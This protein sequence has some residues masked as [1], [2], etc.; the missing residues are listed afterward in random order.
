MTAITLG[1]CDVT[2]FAN[3]TR[4]RTFCNSENCSVISESKFVHRALSGR[5]QLQIKLT[6]ESL[7]PVGIIYMWLAATGFDFVP[8]S[9]TL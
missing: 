5:Y 4:A 2:V 9:V 6:L 7:I 3:G 8:R 1:N